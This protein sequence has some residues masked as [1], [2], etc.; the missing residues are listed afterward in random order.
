MDPQNQSMCV[1]CIGHWLFKKKE[2]IDN[3]T[4]LGI[5]LVSILH[6]VL[7]LDIGLRL[8]NHHP[9]EGRHGLGDLEAGQL[10]DLRTREPV[11]W[12]R[13]HIL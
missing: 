6:G 3:K 11:Y 8:L 13:N 5:V 7:R 1:R 9:A 4:D 10:P 12:D 2:I